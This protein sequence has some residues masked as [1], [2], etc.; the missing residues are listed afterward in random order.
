MHEHAQL[1]VEAAVESYLQQH[2]SA[3]EYWTAFGEEIPAEVYGQNPRTEF[4]TAFAALKGLHPESSLLL[5]K[6]E[7]FASHWAT[8]WSDAAFLMGQAMGKKNVAR[9]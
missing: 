8:R 6:L 5:L 3:P 7:R 2:D 9:K 4:Y 1:L